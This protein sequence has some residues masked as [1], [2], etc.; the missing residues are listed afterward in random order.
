MGIFSGGRCPFTRTPGAP[1]PTSH[2][3][4]FPAL[5]LAQ[6]IDP[7]GLSCGQTTIITNHTELLPADQRERSSLQR[8]RRSPLTARR[9]Y[10]YADEV[11]PKMLAPRNI[12]TLSADA[13]HVLGMMRGTS[14]RG[15][16][17]RAAWP[18]H[19]TVEIG[20]ASA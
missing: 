19:P 7:D 12:Q 13:E 16:G 18:F 15:C 6:K 1:P 3:Q 9:L 8:G 11:L 14:P 20:R 10:R 4:L 5:A 2:I 17:G